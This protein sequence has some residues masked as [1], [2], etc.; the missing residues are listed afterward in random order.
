[1]RAL[2]FGDLEELERQFGGGHGASLPFLPPEEGTNPSLMVRGAARKKTAVNA[3]KMP[4]TAENLMDCRA[5]IVILGG[6]VAA[7]AAA[8]EIRRHSKTASVTII[9]REKRLPY[10]RPMLSKGLL[11]SFAMDRYPIVEENWLQEE[12]VTFLGG[13][14]VSALDA[15]GH[16][17]TLADG[18]KYTGGTDTISVTVE[19]ASEGE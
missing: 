12:N 5:N 13:V 15:A 7:I 19:A 16:T 18:E 1:M 11:N 10:C 9:S 4:N 14:E 2:H 8:K 3:V 17:V 6:G